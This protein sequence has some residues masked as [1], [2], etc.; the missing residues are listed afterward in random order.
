MIGA[1]VEV[2]L[3]YSSNVRARSYSQRNPVPPWQFEIRKISSGNDNESEGEASSDES[4]GQ[5]T[6]ELDHLYC[7]VLDWQAP[8]NYVFVPR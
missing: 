7:H 5:G 3:P 8:R 4:K 1:L 6:C 2:S